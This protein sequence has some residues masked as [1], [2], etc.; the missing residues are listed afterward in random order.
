[1]AAEFDFVREA[2]A[3]VAAAEAAAT[4][5][6]STTEEDPV[7]TDYNEFMEGKFEEMGDDA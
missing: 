2:H 6:A 5:H 4:A 1:M 7:E 3:E